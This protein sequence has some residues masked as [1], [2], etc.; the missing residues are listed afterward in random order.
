MEPEALEVQAVGLE[1]LTL[2]TQPEDGAPCG[3]IWEFLDTP[4]YP[5]Y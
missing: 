2:S 5:V 4:L 3:N 1:L